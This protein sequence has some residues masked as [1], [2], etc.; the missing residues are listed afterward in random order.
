[1]EFSIEPGDDP[2]DLEIS[3][4][5]VPT[6]GDFRR[7]MEALEDDPRAHAGAS[8]LVDV[9]ALDVSVFGDNELMVAST[10]PV[11]VRDWMHPAL[12]VALVAPSDAAFEAATRWRAH[13]GGTRSRREVFRT[14][15]DAVGWL[16]Q[17]SAPKLPDNQ[18]RKRE[19]AR[20]PRDGRLVRT[21][22]VEA[23]MR[24]PRSTPC[25]RSG[26]RVVLA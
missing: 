3:V 8:M 26:S 14:R 15:E 11:S 7:L 24:L 12:A 6:P 19:A 18:R 23:G 2:V 17:Q 9:S 4:T 21:G 10:A 25:L 5:G 20:C 1:V 16:G 22:R 13:L